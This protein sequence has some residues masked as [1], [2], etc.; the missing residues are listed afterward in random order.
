MSTKVHVLGLDSALTVHYTAIQSLS[1]KI[2]TSGSFCQRY[3]R[4]DFKL[5]DIILKLNEVKASLY[6]TED[7][8]KTT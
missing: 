3:N 8:K 1:S 7:S 5:G 2:I 6:T 4:K